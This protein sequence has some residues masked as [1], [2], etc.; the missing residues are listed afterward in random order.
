ML[1]SRVKP[2]LR[3]MKPH[4]VARFERRFVVQDK[5]S[6]LFLMPLEGD[7][8]F[9]SWLHEAGRFDEF[10]EAADT[11]AMN[12]GEGFFISSVC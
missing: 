8:G 9:T 2:A 4:D 3:K 7:V 12:C 10:E 11:G 6:G 1:V 5:E